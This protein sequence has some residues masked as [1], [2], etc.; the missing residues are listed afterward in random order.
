VEEGKLAAA[1]AH[2]VTHRALRQPLYGIWCY[3]SR[4]FIAAT[5][6]APGGLFT[7]TCWHR[8]TEKK[9]GRMNRTVR[10]GIHHYPC[11]AVRS[12]HLKHGAYLRYCA[13][14]LPV[15]LVCT[16]FLMFPLL[17]RFCCCLRHCLFHL[18]STEG[19]GWRLGGG[20]REGK[21][22]NDGRRRRH[23]LL[24]LPVCALHAPQQA[25]HLLPHLPC[26]LHLLH[27]AHCT[28]PIYSWPYW[29]DTCTTSQ[30]CYL[31]YHHFCS[32]ATSTRGLC[33]GVLGGQTQG[34]SQTAATAS[35]K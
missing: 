33:A 8:W 17:W 14:R 23:L 34:A 18:I 31:Y 20:G 2:G 3:H 11:A 9:A 13:S 10:C 32:K 16:V 26:L 22:G 6:A 7:Y 27:S 19:K 35:R 4:A 12:C 21:G 1:R 30:H 15:T 29:R 24:R 25:T 28:I 5:Y